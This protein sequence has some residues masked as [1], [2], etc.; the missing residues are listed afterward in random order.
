MTYRY[1]MKCPEGQLPNPS[2][3][4]STPTASTS[5]VMSF[6][7]PQSPVDLGAD[8]AG[9]RG[10]E[11]AGDQG[12]QTPADHGAQADAESGAQAAAGTPLENLLKG[13]EMNRSRDEP[14]YELEN[15]FIL[16]LPPEHA[17]AVRKIV[18]STSV[19]MKDKL[20]IDLSPDGRHAVVEVEDV[21]LT[22]N[23]VDLPCVIGSLKTLDK[24]TFYKTADISQMLVCTADGDPH[25]SPEEPTTSTDLKVIAKNERE[26]EK[27]YVWK[28]GITPP[29]KN[30][31]KKRFRK[32]T[33]KLIDFEEINCTEEKGIPAK[34][35]VLN[36]VPGIPFSPTLVQY[37]ESPEVEKEVKKLLCS[38]AEAVSTRW[39]VIAEDE[40]KEIESQGF[41]PGFKISPGM[42]GYKQGHVSSECEMLR[43]MFSD[44][45]S[46]SDKD[47][48]DDEEEEDDYDDDEDEEEEKD[49]YEEDV[50]RKLQAKFIEPGQHEAK[51]RASSIAMEI[52][53]QIHHMEKKLLE[54]QCKAQRQKNLIMKLENLMLKNHLQSVLE[55]LKLEEKEKNEQNENPHWYGVT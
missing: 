31:R 5:E 4:D 30:V 10:A 33:K 51:E 54:I 34:H 32:T 22:A 16:R 53:K 17:S 43:E 19:A 47:D 48:D 7:D 42:S 40:T 9:D 28:H 45:S 6:H 18:H 41:I 29:L 2:E 15:Q 1:T 26:G 35:R 37:I 20:K 13:T 25:S 14:P 49:Y 3:K 11:T 55:Q 52:Q 23:L 46:N 24:K 27:K 50:E 8:T 38:D 12:S 21:S 36:D 39:E 44:S